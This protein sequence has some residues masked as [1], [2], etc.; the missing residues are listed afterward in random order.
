MII[1]NLINK[2]LINF[3]SKKVNLIV[4]NDVHGSTKHIDSFLAEQDKF[5]KQNPNNMNLTL[6]GGDLF[7]DESP[8]NEIVA[9]KVAKVTDGIAVG[10]HDI[11][12]GNHLAELI[13]KFDMFKKWLS[14]NV[15]FNKETPLENKICRSN[16]IEKNGEKFGVIGV[17]PFDFGK[18]S[19]VND[20][21]NFIKMKS[22][23]QTIEEIKK[24]VLSL[25]NQGVNMIFL[26]AHT[27]EKS[28]IGENYYDEFA[29][30]GDID[31]IVGG[32]D[33]IEINRW[34]N[35]V[36]GEPVKII[37]TGKN[38]SHKFGE[39]LD[40]ICKLNLEFDD[41]GVLI[42]EKSTTEFVNLKENNINKIDSEVLYN[43]E[44]PL[45][46]SDI[47]QGHSEIGNLVADSNLWYVN[48]YTKGK[49]ADFAIV[50]PGTI[51]D[52]ITSINITE[53]EIKDVL[54]FI[55][56]KLIKTTLTK[57]QILDTLSW[58][59]LSTSFSKVSPGIMQVSNMEYTINPDLTVSNVHI[60]NDDGTI[61]YNLDNY[62]D[63]KKFSAV[64]DTFLATGVA[65]LKALIKV[66]ENNPD[67]ELFHVPRQD[68]LIEYLSKAKKLMDYKRVRILKK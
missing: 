54:P 38:S 1:N 29:K 53:D 31:V 48:K 37:S 56:N 13:E 4:Y 26:L 58:G 52:N 62:D 27:G 15:G 43:L 10:N 34:A 51:R 49:K 11:D 23:V 67:V 46:S 41:N 20:K 68:A 8:N 42:K 40:M 63:D 24:E 60:L 22:L 28:S 18:I 3:Q 17:S 32:H 19:F 66:C 6:C 16:V 44:E 7:L 39:N 45:K 9:A 36:S 61:K 59:A 64:Y 35:S 30:I 14:V 65:G 57:K 12:A 55:S 5:Y 47:K 25:K 50:N 2:S 33:H 21:T